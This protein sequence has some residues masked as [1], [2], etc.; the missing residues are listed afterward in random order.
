MRTLSDKREL[1]RSAGP[2]ADRKRCLSLSARLAR[3][4]SHKTGRPATYSGQIYR[5]TGSVEK[6]GHSELGEE[7]RA[8][9]FSWCL[10]PR[11]ERPRNKIGSRVNEIICVTSR[12]WLDFPVITVHKLFRNGVSRRISSRITR[13]L[14]VRFHASP[15]TFSL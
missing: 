3:K 1:C 5:D 14:R 4:Y 2:L 15:A 8:L 9:S 6:K 11:V 13:L 10:R 12:S 7:A